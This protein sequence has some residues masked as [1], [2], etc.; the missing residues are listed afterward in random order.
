M[1]RLERVESH[2]RADGDG[3][4]GGAAEFIRQV[5]QLN[6][7]ARGEDGGALDN[8]AQLAEVAG[9]LVAGE[10]RGD[11][12]RKGGD[13]FAE[14]RGE[15]FPIALGESCEVGGPFAQA[16]QGDAD[17]VEPVKQILAEAAGLHLGGEIAVGRG[18]DADVGAARLRFADAL[19]FALL[20]E[21]K[22]FRLDFRRQFA[23][24]VEEQRA[25]V[26]G[27]DFAERV[28]DRAGKGAFGVP[29]QLALEEL[30]RK[31]RATDGD[32]RGFALRAARMDFAGEHA[33]AGAAW[34]EKEHRR[35]RG[36]GLE[37]DLDRALR[38]G[39][40]GLEV[41]GWRFAGE[42]AFK[43]A[44]ARLE[45]AGLFDL[46]EDGANL[47]GRERLWDE[48]ESAEPHRLDCGRDVG[49]GREHHD[50]G[51]RLRLQQFR[52]R[53]E[54]VVGAEFQ[55]EED[56]IERFVGDGFQRARGI[57]R[58]GGG[59]TGGLDGDARRFADAGFVINDEDA[60]ERRVW[61]KRRAVKCQFT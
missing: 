15:E 43:R 37:C 49:V 27:G 56:S 11:R 60:H 44:H 32:E 17:Y 13:F 47:V 55:V 3:G 40:G 21:A 39:L 54:T 16:G 29:E 25:A 22:Q 50:G 58:L 46:G 14:A 38:G 7:L 57:G 51:R 45:G 10:G 59:V 5:A 18:D 4:I 35:R 61:R 53:V 2:A 30:A 36:R 1:L 42:R 31:R 9:P 34:A 28:D 26:G 20:E 23:D 19:V 8:V 41:D 33:L 52:E 12:R 24:F 6:R 48:I